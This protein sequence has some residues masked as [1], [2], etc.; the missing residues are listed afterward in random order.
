MSYR[1]DDDAPEVEEY[2]QKFAD[3]DDAWHEELVKN[4]GKRRAGDIRYYPEGKGQPGDA[5][6]A[7]YVARMKAHE[8]YYEFCKNGGSPKP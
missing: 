8:A 3:A 6:N 4:F 5:I 2:Y 1:D 7:A